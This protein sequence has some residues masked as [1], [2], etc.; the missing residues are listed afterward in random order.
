MATDKLTNA[1]SGEEE[2]T[3]MDLL[4]TVN[5]CLSKSRGILNAVRC[6]DYLDRNLVESALWA[7]DDILVEA[8][9]A[10]LNWM[11]IKIERERVAPGA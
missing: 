1:T 10:L 5:A 4:D 9:E 6:A 7:A 11:T 3:D 2:F 8:K